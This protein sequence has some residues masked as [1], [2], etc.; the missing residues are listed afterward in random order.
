VDSFKYSDQNSDAWS[1]NESLA[2]LSLYIEHHFPRVDNVITP[3][4]QLV[5]SLY[6]YSTEDGVAVLYE[7]SRGKVWELER[8]ASHM[9]IEQVA[10]SDDGRLAAIADLSGRLSIKT[11]AKESQD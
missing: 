1:K 2:K 11:I 9:S 10:W 4:S 7:V 5:R 6:C 8:L 3:S